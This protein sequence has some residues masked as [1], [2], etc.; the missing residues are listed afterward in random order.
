M[1]LPSRPAH[2]GGSKPANSTEL[3]L[4]KTIWRG[5]L[6]CPSFVWL[7]TKRYNFITVEQPYPG[8]ILRD[9]GQT[10]I[11]GIKFAE[12]YVD[13]VFSTLCEVFDRGLTALAPDLHRPNHPIR[14]DRGTNHDINRGCPS[15]SAPAQN[16]TRGIPAWLPPRVCARCP[17]SE[18]AR[19]SNCNH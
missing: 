6:F 5:N 19:A 10:T 16:R 18:G 8:S 11:S 7:N 2:G 17:A 1:S 13:G 15:L 4:P 3:Y 14:R 12:F 9:Y